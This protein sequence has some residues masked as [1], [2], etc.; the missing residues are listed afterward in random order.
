MTVSADVLVDNEVSNSTLHSAVG[1]AKRRFLWFLVLF[2]CVAVVDRVNVS[3]AALTMNRA[4]GLTAAA[5]GFGASLFLIGSI[6]FEVPS[7][8]MMARFG[9]RKWLARIGITWGLLTMV[10]AYIPGERSFYVVRFLIGAAE[11]GAYPGILL[12]IA[13]WFPKAYR[14]EINA[15]FLLSIPLT[16]GISSP[17]AAAVMTLDGHMLLAGW[18]W[19][20]LIEGLFSISVGVVAYFFLTDRPSQ[21]T[22]LPE[23]ERTA[24]VDALAAEQANLDASAKSTLRETLTSGPVWL[25]GAMYSGLGVSLV[26]AAFWMPQILKASGL[27][28]T[29]IGYAVA[30]TFA[31]GAV[32][33]VIWGRHSDKTG[34]RFAHTAFPAFVAALGWLLT[35]FSGQP[36]FLIAALSV[37]TIGHFSSSAA[38]WTI[39]PRYL[40]GIGATAAGFA[41]V[42]TISHVTSAL[43]L[44]IIGIVKD[45]TGGFRVGLIVVSL[46]MLVTPLCVLLLKVLYRSKAND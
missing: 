7:N 46:Y 29:E 18:Q 27:P 38:M 21:A 42:T 37:V 28:N 13:T 26:T 30:F 6:F 14:A 8:I 25:L 40:S 2:Y 23:A 16:N 34:E 1:K 36:M 35:A 17:L 4:L 32:A 19:L 11:A 9:A 10:M 31:V 20:F 3:F 39:P 41:M 33:M 12:Y 45:A 44:S 5:F 24:L 22:W 15:L 43:G